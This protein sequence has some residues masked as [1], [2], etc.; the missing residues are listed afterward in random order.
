MKIRFGYVA[1]ALD[2]WDASPSKTLTFA[3]YS[4]LPKNERMEKLK[5]I[6]ALNLHHSKRIL[7]YNIA[8]EIEVYRF[9]SALVPLATHP[10][11]MWDFITPFKKEWTELGQL[12]KQNN[13]RVSFHPSQYTL[14]TSPRDEV[15]MN[16]V[17][18]MEYHYKMLQAMNV[19]DTGLINIHIGGSYGDK[20][21][22]LT[23]FHQNLKTLPVEIKKR[24]TL[25]NDDKTY[26]VHETL[27]TCEQESIPMVLDYHHF[28][29][30]K[31]D[32]ELDHYLQRIFNTWTTFNMVPKVHISSP[33]SDQAYR[34]HADFVSLEFVLPFLKMAKELGQDF[35]IMIEAKQKN[36]AMQRLVEEVAAIRGIK[37]ITSSSV[38][39]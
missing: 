5:S 23:R 13:L 3:R 10:E 4:A 7:Y 25:E 8:H 29:A 22:T 1:H 37:R 39:W 9:S 28:M 36:L 30:N 6:T 16:A 18:D 26:D 34:S 2:L 38:E 12:I 21:E 17:K 31:G 32:V 14:F 33:K 15:T 11:V 20:K 24:M 19:H 35:D 27:I